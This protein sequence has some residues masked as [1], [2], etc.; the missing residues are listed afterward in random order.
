MVSVVS[1]ELIAQK[2]KT[3]LM[4]G[5]LFPRQFFFGLHSD[6]ADFPQ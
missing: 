4:T 3:I 6:A 5:G 2:I 1:F